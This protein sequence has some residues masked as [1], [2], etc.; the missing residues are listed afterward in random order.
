MLLCLAGP[1]ESSFSPFK[2]NVLC[3]VN[4]TI[5]YE[6]KT[7]YI[8]K[9]DTSAAPPITRT[10]VLDSRRGAAI[11]KIDWDGQKPV[12]IDFGGADERL[13]MDMVLPT[14]VQYVQAR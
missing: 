8:W 13:L 14:T 1:P 3:D 2:E 12:Y 6:F 9:A 7:E 5:V 10:T 4:G 11:A